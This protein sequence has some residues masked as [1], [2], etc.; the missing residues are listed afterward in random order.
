[1]RSTHRTPAAPV[2]RR[3]FGMTALAGVSG[4]CWSPE[5]RGPGPRDDRLRGSRTSRSAPSPTASAA[6]RTRR[7]HR[8]LSDDRARRDGTDVEPR[9]SAGRRATVPGRAAAAARRS[10]RSSRPRPRARGDR[11][12]QTGAGRD[13]GDLGA[14]AQED[15]GRRHRPAPA[16]LQHER[17]NDEGRRHRVRLQD[18]RRARR[19]GDLDVD[20]GQHGQA[21]WRRSPTSTR[22]W[23]ASTAT[24][25]T[26]DPTKSRSPKVRRR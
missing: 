16:L 18:G 7:H 8:A 21:H 23:S 20:P 3:Q 4:S 14:R 25:N 22:C 19:Q 2:T 17:P 5:P 24:T 10:P 12:V 26:T 11:A 6:S 15:R 9:R 13:R 1:M